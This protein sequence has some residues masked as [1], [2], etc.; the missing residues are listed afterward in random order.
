MTPLALI[1]HGATAWNEQSRVLGRADPPLSPAG[2]AA[3]RRWR[4]PAE[5]AGF[6]VVA[7]PLRRARETAEI[8]FG[9]PVALD[10][11]LV[12]IDWG[13]W[14]GRSLADLRREIGDLRAAWQARGLDFRAPNGESPRDVQAR[15]RP[16]LAERAASGAATAAVCHRGVIQA[17][18]ALATGWDMRSPPTHR[19]A[20]ACAHL[21]VLAEDGSPSLRRVNLRLSRE[22]GR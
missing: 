3:V 13:A 1:R 18:Y 12:E 7:S 14:E 6:S 10:A 11:R 15:L 22:A 16:F 21:F 4:I 2:R 19:L 5:L 9:V 8:L 17:L 20:D